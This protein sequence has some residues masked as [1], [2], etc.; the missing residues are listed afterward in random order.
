M[1]ICTRDPRRV[2]GFFE[3]WVRDFVGVS[4]LF[5]IKRDESKR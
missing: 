5:L 4:G 1:A 2:L 3:E